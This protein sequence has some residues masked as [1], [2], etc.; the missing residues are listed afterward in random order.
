[1]SVRLVRFAENSVR[2]MRNPPSRVSRSRGVPRPEHYPTRGSAAAVLTLGRCL[3]SSKRLECD[4]GVS[5]MNVLRWR[6]TRWG[7]SELLTAEAV[8]VV[9]MACDCMLEV[10]DMKS[11]PRILLGSC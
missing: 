3:A 7:T 8:L 9:S 11:A 4:F 1:M 5:P 2:A 6:E 10:R